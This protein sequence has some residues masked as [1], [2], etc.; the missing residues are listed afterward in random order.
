M[1]SPETIRALERDQAKKAARAKKKPYVPFDEAEIRSYAVDGVP[2]P[3]PNIGSYRPN[4]WTLVEELFCD[5]SGLGAD[6]EPA[7]THNQLKQKLI[8]HVN[9]DKNYGYAIISEGQFQLYI[10][11]FEKEE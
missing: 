9:S 7:L 10:G 8:E 2:F 6:W 5:K 4:G 3:F 11:V 1:M